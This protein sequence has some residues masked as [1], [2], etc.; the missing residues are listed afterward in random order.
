M[1]HGFVATWTAYDP[2]WLVDLASNQHS[3]RPWL[4]EALERCTR[5]LAESKAYVYFVDPQNANEPGARW[6][7]R[8][9]VV[10]A[11]RE[12][13]VVLDVLADGSIGG[14]EFLWLI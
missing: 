5:G 14:A 4:A 9:N 6:Q 11:S 7:F 10:L 1:R 3:D 2:A 8:E 12:G 13:D